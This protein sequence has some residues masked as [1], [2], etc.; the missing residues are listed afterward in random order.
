M[1]AKRTM[2]VLMTMKCTMTMTPTAMTI[3]T[4][5]WTASAV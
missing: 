2:A 4:P 5:G 1:T 3:I